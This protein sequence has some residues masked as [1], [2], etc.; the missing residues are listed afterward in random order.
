MFWSMINNRYKLRLDHSKRIFS[1]KN[2]FD[3][4]LVTFLKY[5]VLFWLITLNFK[6]HQDAPI[7][8][9]FYFTKF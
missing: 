4:Y 6:V 5:Y 3:R 2:V 9:S 7:R 1:S 8:I